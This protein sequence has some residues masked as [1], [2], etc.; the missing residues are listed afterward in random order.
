MTEMQYDL[1]ARYSLM[2]VYT[3]QNMAQSC[4]LCTI[5][6]FILKSTLT[7]MFYM[8]NKSIQKWKQLLFGMGSIFYI[9]IFLKSFM[10]NKSKTFI[11]LESLIQ[12]VF[13][14]EFENNFSITDKKPSTL[15]ENLSEEHVKRC[16]Y[17]SYIQN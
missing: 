12:L 9:K 6:S 14:P 11:L 3:I 15:M 10:E 7:N 17:S 16:A 2:Y 5:M 13:R 4:L 8:G 1:T